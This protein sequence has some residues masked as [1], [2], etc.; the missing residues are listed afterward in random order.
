M[1]RVSD[2]KYIDDIKTLSAKREI[3]FFCKEKNA[4]KSCGVRKMYKAIIEYLS[5]IYSR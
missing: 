2:K 4:S 5:W 3:V 1:L